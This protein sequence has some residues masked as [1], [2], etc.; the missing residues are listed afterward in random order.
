MYTV[1]AK[2]SDCRA[3]AKG[4]PLAAVCK[5]HSS[6][7]QE[8]SR[9]LVICF[10]FFFFLPF[11]LNSWK[12]YANCFTGRASQ[13]IWS[14][15]TECPRLQKATQTHW[16][17]PEPSLDTPRTVLPQ[18]LPQASTQAPCS[19]WKHQQWCGQQELTFGA[20]VL[21]TAFLNSDSSSADD[22]KSTEH[23]THPCR[24]DPAP[25]SPCSYEYWEPETRFKQL[26]VLLVFKIP[27]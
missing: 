9:W 22:E 17:M 24:G 25:K 18:Q 3:Q 23:R 1:I 27:M 20:N 16:V 4:F 7:R 6:P 26:Q 10:F 2:N 14:H 11:F 5:G 15:G 8:H 13:L 19:C 21:S 12:Q